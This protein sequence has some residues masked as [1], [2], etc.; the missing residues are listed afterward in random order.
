MARCSAEGR[1][2]GGGGKERGAAG[3]LAGCATC[4]IAHMAPPPHASS[5]S[6][7]DDVGLTVGG[8]G[9]GRGA[10]T[11]LSRKTAR[12][13]CGGRVRTRSHFDLSTG[14]PRHS[15]H[16]HARIHARTH[17][18]LAGVQA[19]AMRPLKAV[20]PGERGGTSTLPP[21]DHD[22]PHD[23]MYIFIFPL[24]HVQTDPEMCMGCRGGGGE[25]GGGG[26]STNSSIKSIK[27]RMLAASLHSR[28]CVFQT[29]ER[30]FAMG[31][32]SLRHAAVKRCGGCGEYLCL[33]PM[34]GPG[35]VLLGRLRGL[36]LALHLPAPSESQSGC[37]AR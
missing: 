30:C 15:T 29:L 8:W 33:K 18:T 6:R 5:S 3:R 7:P 27:S 22:P 32:G 2:V 26:H 9:G 37:V 25:E 20:G 21:N 28:H 36:P 24:M 14:D 17:A 34:A 13:A 1:G 19:R 10:A 23:T 4:A 35:G 11:T 12:K 16:T 31:G